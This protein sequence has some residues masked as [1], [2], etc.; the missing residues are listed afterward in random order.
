MILN[1]KVTFSGALSCFQYWTSDLSI[2]SCFM[3]IFNYLHM[4][5]KLGCA[6]VN[7]FL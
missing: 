4:L 6:Y 7:T 5:L 3:D 2:F 1:I